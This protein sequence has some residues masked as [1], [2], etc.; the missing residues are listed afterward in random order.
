MP[1]TKPRS[2][3]L[4]LVEIATMAYVVLRKRHGESSHLVTH[5]V[6]ISREYFEQQGESQRQYISPKLL[7][8]CP[9]RS[10]VDFGYCLEH[11][12]QPQPSYWS[13]RNCRF[14]LGTLPHPPLPHPPLH[15]F[16]C[17]ISSLYSTFYSPSPTHP[18]P[19]TPPLTLLSPL[20][21]PLA[22]SCPS[23]LS[24]LFPSNLSYGIIIH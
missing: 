5:K 7:I 17:L 20:T 10:D 24:P 18:S 15:S 8:E 11:F 3:L 9:S 1:F 13:S 14:L 21:L 22:P 12:R 16:Y 23:L 2:V 19:L 6:G 4:L